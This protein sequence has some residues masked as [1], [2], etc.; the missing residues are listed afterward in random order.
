M[1]QQGSCSVDEHDHQDPKWKRMHKMATPTAFLVM[2]LEKRGHGP[3]ATGKEQQRHQPALF[4][5]QH[6]AKQQPTPFGRGGRPKDE[7]LEQPL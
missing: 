2:N 1:G 7:R 4:L 3:Q 6:D 5:H